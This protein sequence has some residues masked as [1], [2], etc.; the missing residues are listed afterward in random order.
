M[1][2]KTAKPVFMVYLHDEE[3]TT[4]CH[5]GKMWLPPGSRFQQHHGNILEL[6]HK[7]DIGC[8]GTLHKQVQ[9][10]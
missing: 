5:D 2:A 10:R 4:F 7:V 6:H 8:Y 9:G 1:R 3:D